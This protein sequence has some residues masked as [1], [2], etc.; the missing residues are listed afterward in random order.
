MFY[1]LCFQFTLSLVIFILYTGICISVSSRVWGHSRM[2]PPE[3][4][5][6]DRG[7]PEWTPNP[8]RI[9]RL[10]R[11]PEPSRRGPPPPEWRFAPGDTPEFGAFVGVTPPPERD[12]LICTSMM[13]SEI[14]D[15]CSRS[16][17]H[18][19]YHTVSHN[20]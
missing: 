8:P 10:R 17:F 19:T 7:S 15:S 16:L 3:W 2:G 12:T 18:L 13:N 4:S 9:G 1:S 5:S 11:R 6:A 20:D 14:E